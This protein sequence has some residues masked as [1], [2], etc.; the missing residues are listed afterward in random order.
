MALCIRNPRAEKLAREVASLSE[1]N[2]TRAVIHA[3]EDRLERLKGTREIINTFEEIMTISQRCSSLP[4]LDI[5][6][7]E[8]ILDYDQIGGF[9]GN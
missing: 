3:L 9:G 1:E 5:R 7:P 4:D 8:E 2:L 6:P